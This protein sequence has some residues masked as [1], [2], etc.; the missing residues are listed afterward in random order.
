[1]VKDDVPPPL[2]D[3]EK[4]ANAGVERAGGRVEFQRLD[5]GGFG[6]IPGKKRQ[7]GPVRAGGQGGNAVAF[8][9]EHLKTVAAAP[10]DGRFTLI[11]TDFEDA[12]CLDDHSGGGDGVDFFGPRLERR[13]FKVE[14]GDGQ[15]EGEDLANVFGHLVGG[16][17]DGEEI[18]HELRPLLDLAAHFMG[19]FQQLLAP[20]WV[21]G[22]ETC[23]EGNEADGQA[24][25]QEDAHTRGQHQALQLVGAARGRGVA[26]FQRSHEA[27][28]T[29]QRHISGKL[30]PTW[31]AC[32]GLSDVGVIPGWVLVSK[33]IRPSMPLVSS[34]R[35]SVRLTPLQPSA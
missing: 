8:P 22:P 15:V 6:T 18:D 14:G 27:S 20:V 11:D 21:G 3:A 33:R 32:S 25:A 16:A 17:F 31:A 7:I 12:A 4:A 10:D 13:E 2:P 35:K 24:P 28:S 30:M 9:V 5:N 19:G 23:G 34:Q 26:A 29:I 1:M